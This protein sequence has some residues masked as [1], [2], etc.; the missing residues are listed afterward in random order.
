M[1]AKYPV[2]H[3]VEHLADAL[4]FARLHGGLQQR[5]DRGLAADQESSGD[6]HKEQ[7]GDDDH[8]GGFFVLVRAAAPGT[9][10]G[11]RGN[12]RKVRLDE[13]SHSFGASLTGLHGGM[14]QQNRC[15]ADKKSLRIESNRTI[16][17]NP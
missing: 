14:K 10:S 9:P 4:G 12:A 8:A 11:A 16:A 7:R 6:E 3:P 2:R 1:A 5:I 17:R 15:A 13:P